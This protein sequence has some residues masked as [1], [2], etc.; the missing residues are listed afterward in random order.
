MAAVLK[1]A[2]AAMSSWV[3]IPHPPRMLALR[4]ARA[5]GTL[6]GGDMST[7]GAWLRANRGLTVTMT[8][9]VV[10]MVSIYVGTNQIFPDTQYYV[11]WTYR[12]MGYSD[13]DSQQL[14]IDFIRST[15]VFEPY[16][17]L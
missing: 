2:M 17:Y 3:R 16:S 15:G 13:A 9:T 10:A 4:S 1:T 14:T 12:L 11:A 7:I 6:T 8:V 5:A